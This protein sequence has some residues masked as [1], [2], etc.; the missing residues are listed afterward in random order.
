MRPLVGILVSKSTNEAPR[1]FRG[2]RT[3]TKGKIHTNTKRSLRK[4]PHASQNTT[5]LAF[6]VLLSPYGLHAD[7][8]HRRRLRGDRKVS[9]R[10]P[11]TVAV[12]KS[13]RSSIGEAPREGNSDKETIR[14]LQ[15][16]FE[17]QLATRKRI[18][19]DS[20]AQQ[21]QLKRKKTRKPDF[22]SS[23]FTKHR[24]AKP[25]SHLHLL[26]CKMYSFSSDRLRRQIKTPK[27]QKNRRRIALNQTI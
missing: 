3:N 24:K 17:T 22:L 12:A 6:A 21:K 2:Y 10:T 15:S 8:K 27:N 7:S 5:N 9:Y 25:R 20:E 4:I 23:V 11:I 19:N 18:R 16:R 26:R 13:R 14:T 1:L